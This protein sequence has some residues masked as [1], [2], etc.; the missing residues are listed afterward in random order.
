MPNYLSN[1]PLA[2][3]ATMGGELGHT[4]GQSMYQ[5]PMQRA[6]MMQQIAQMR[7]QQQYH[8]ALMQLAA[9]KQQDMAGYRGGMLDWRNGQLDERTQRDQTLDQ[10]G[11][12]RLQQGDQRL[13]MQENAPR[14]NFL[15]I[16]GGNVIARDGM[17]P[18]GMQQPQGQG[19][20]NGLPSGFQ[21]LS[22][23]H[24]SANVNPN[25]ALANQIKL[26]Q[27]QA[28]VGGT[29]AFPDI[30]QAIGQ[31]RQGG[32]SQPRPMNAMPTNQPPV[33]NWDPTNGLQR[34]EQ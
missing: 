15:P 12:Q 33:F 5:V 25:A 29:N 14:Q 9:Q 26:L 27:L 32:Q 20:T 6:Q 8:Q 11:Q 22:A 28:G 17:M 30:L 4:L 23:P 21:M 2:E 31:L 3:A 24:P 13:Q 1:N 16:G 34:A 7:Q 10:Q 19:Q 18:P